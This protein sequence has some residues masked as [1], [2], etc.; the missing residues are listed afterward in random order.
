[1]RLGMPDT[2]ARSGP[3]EIGPNPASV[4]GETNFQGDLKMAHASVF[5]MPSRFDYFK[6]THVSYGLASLGNC[7]SRCVLDGLSRTSYNL[8]GFVYMIRH[9]LLLRGYI[10]SL[11]I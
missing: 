6:P 7:A 8:D 2:G 4:E 10:V 1:M 5:D 9:G 3:V 11:A